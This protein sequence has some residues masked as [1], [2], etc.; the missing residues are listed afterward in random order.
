MT[1]TVNVNQVLMHEVYLDK[2]NSGYIN[3][4]IYP[5][6]D[7]LYRLIRDVLQQDGLPRTPKQVEVINK[8]VAEIVS[9]NSPWIGYTQDLQE[10][11]LYEMR[12]LAKQAELTGLSNRALLSYIGEQ[13]MV[14]ASGTS[15]RANTGQSKSQ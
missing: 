6:L 5:A 10:A 9:E 15:Q 2:L 3:N 14:L 7:D 4:S 8:L 11:A 12:Y 13:M 1:I